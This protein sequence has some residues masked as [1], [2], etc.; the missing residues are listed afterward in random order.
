MLGLLSTVICLAGANGDAGHAGA[1]AAGAWQATGSLVMG[2]MEHTATLL[3]NGKV[4]VAG[5]SGCM[6]PFV[7]GWICASAE[8]YDPASGQWAAT[9]SMGAA[10]LGHT[11]TLLGNGRVLVAGGSGCQD[12]PVCTS[13]ELY[14]PATGRWVPGGHMSAW[15]FFHTATLLHNGDVLV[16]GGVL[17]AAGACASAELYDPASGRW[18]TTG[19][20]HEGRFLHTATLLPTGR[21]LVAGGEGC[22]PI[23]ICA[24]AELYDPATG[25]WHETGRMTVGREEHTATLLHS[26][27]V[28][29]AGGYGCGPSNVCAGA[30]LYDPATGRWR[31]T[32][33]MAQA[34][35]GHT[36]TLL[37]DGE[38]LAAGGY[39]CDRQGCHHLAS[40]ELYDPATGTWR[41]AG[42]MHRVREYQTATLLTNGRVLLAGGSTG[43]RAPAPCGVTPSAEVYA[44]AGGRAAAH[45]ATHPRGERTLTGQGIRCAITPIGLGPPP[46]PHGIT[47]VWL[48]A[49]PVSSGIVGYLA[50]DRLSH[51]N[52]WMPDGST[53]KIIW[54]DAGGQPVR[55]ATMR[56]L[57]L[58]RHAPWQ[59][60]FNGIPV[61]PQPGCW[62][63]TLPGDKAAGHVTMLVLGD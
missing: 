38:V 19:R 10:R 42:R 8:L 30:E 43:C 2:R 20:L 29:V 11:A 44:P 17:C 21:V 5:G 63:V 50:S 61:F 1:T 48:Q 34:R 22:L 24:S 55:D 32:G 3:P 54:L 6:P 60:F 13:T 25:A 58:G 56:D 9:G 52:G 40:A 28:L 59:P 4:L 47:D 46:R 51:T 26:G 23:H 12:M 15:R 45:P 39:G 62:Q 57:S 16:A 35:A 53:G 27:Q 36:A 33:R 14:D 31:P 7:P 49:R 18:Q 41:A 37:P